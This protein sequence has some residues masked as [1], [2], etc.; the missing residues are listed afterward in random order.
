MQ[1]PTALVEDLST[2]GPDQKG[3]NIQLG[4]GSDAGTVDGSNIVIGANAVMPA[5]FINTAVMGGPTGNHI[6]AF[7]IGNGIQALAPQAMVIIGA[8]S[9]TP[10]GSNDDVAGTSL[11]VAPGKG[12]GI[13]IAATVKIKTPSVGV[14]GDAAQVLADRITIREVSTT[15]HN[16]LT[17][18]SSVGIGSAGSGSITVPGVGTASEQ[19]GAGAVAGAART[20]AIGSSAQASATNSTAIGSAATAV[21]SSVAVGSLASVTG[22]GSSVAIGF[23]ASVAGV[24]AV[25]VGGSAV[26]DGANTIAIGQNANANT[27][28]SIILIGKNATVTGSNGVCIGTSS[29]AGSSSTI[30]GAFSTSAGSNNICLGGSTALGSFVGC[31]TLGVTSN[32]TANN[33]LVLGGTGNSIA[34]A[35]IGRGVDSIANRSSIIIQGTR[36]TAG[37][38][39]DR[40]GTSL[41]IASGE[42]TGSGAASTITFQTPDVLGSGTT[43]Q[44]LVT[45]LA[46]SEGAI[47]IGSA[48]DEAITIGTPGGTLGFFGATAVVQQANVPTLTDSSG[49]AANDV[50]AAITNAANAGSADVGPTADAIADLA[51]K[52]NA[53]LTILENLGLMA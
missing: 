27:Q 29:T 39:A 26:A 44:G 32:P 4:V 38:I 31:I 53:V 47:T 52:V 28:S 1:M 13:G 5:G 36:A 23:S 20:T 48:S 16:G 33:Q 15:I 14:T 40:F 22:L 3:T 2:R 8:T 34:H 9:A 43:Q 21:L 37:V 30:V 10:G 50:I 41:V 17:V 46:L 35:F 45:R 51:A 18:A 12:T 42:G 7:H 49:G 24:S 19:F 11:V 6:D 25:A